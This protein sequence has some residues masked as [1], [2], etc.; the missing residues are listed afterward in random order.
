MPRAPRGGKNK[1]SYR[2]VVCGHCKKTVGFTATY[3]HDRSQHPRLNPYWLELEHAGQREISDF[4]Q[5]ENNR[6]TTEQQNPSMPESSLVIDDGSPATEISSHGQP[7]NQPDEEQPAVID[8]EAEQKDDEGV[9]NNTPS[10]SRT[11]PILPEQSLIV[12]GAFSTIPVS[13]TAHVL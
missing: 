4:L 11:K 6:T 3:R 2:N 12:T 9:K 13:L 10:T 5:P 8:L 7:S 1:R